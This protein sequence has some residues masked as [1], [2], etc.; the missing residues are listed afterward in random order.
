MMGDSAS[1]TMIGV[2]GGA[3]GALVG[4]PIIIGLVIGSAGMTACENGFAVSYSEIE[5][6]PAADYLEQFSQN[7]QDEKFALIKEIYR[8]GAE[9]AIPA[10]P[11]A[12]KTVISTGI[13]ETELTNLLECNPEGENQ[14][15][16]GFLQQRPSQDWGS[17]DQITDPYYA[18]NAFLDRYDKQQDVENRSMKSIAL[19]IQ[20][21]R[22]S[23]YDRWNWDR[24]A[25]E[26]YEMAIGSN[27]R[28]SCQQS[29][30]W[31]SPMPSHSVNSDRYGMRKLFRDKPPSMHWG[32]DMATDEGE[33]IYAAHSG[34]IEYIGENGQLGNFVR[35]AHDGEIFT[36][37]AHMV[38]FVSGLGKGDYVDV[39]DPIGY[40]GDTGLSFGDHLHFEVTVEGKRVD[41][42]TFFL[43]RGID[44]TKP[45]G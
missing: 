25:E 37:Y 28:G 12:I 6:M 7:E 8:A 4:I 19:A 29:T 31:Q 45:S 15:S 30:E 23:A 20:R 10:T 5:G 11:K 44:L 26:L 39:G 33:T 32:V 41:P 27:G 34:V 40:V 36:G 9:R 42:L 21:P 24:T 3:L 35:I 18:T 13:Q 22:I 2:F 17:C 14:D 38:R 16:G 43:E 1:G